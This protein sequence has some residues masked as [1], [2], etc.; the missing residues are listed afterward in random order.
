MK[1]VELRF[2]NQE[3][4][5]DV[6][7]H[8]TKDSVPHILDWYGAFYAGDDYAVFINGRAQPLGING[9]LEPLVI[10]ATPANTNSP[11]APS[12]MP[13]GDGR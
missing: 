11:H 12:E 10:D 5:G 7:L 8:C 9:E 4:K 2:C 3:V 6:V 1:N 13:I